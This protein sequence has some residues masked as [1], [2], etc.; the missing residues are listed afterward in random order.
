MNLLSRSVPASHRLISLVEWCLV[1]LSTCRDRS[2]AVLWAGWVWGRRFSARAAARKKALQR[3]IKLHSR[4]SILRP[5]EQKDR[6]NFF[7]YSH[8]FPALPT[9]PG[10]KNIVFNVLVKGLKLNLVPMRWREWTQKVIYLKLT[11][12]KGFQNSESDRVES[13]DETLGQNESGVKDLSECAWGKGSHWPLGKD[14]SVWTCSVL[15]QRW[16]ASLIVANSSSHLPVCLFLS[17]IWTSKWF[18][19]SFPEA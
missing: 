17:L 11:T 6:V 10:E 14:S 7:F 18:K 19:R 5:P 12:F 3:E 8:H 2:N 4:F 16:I 15:L 9:G 1:L 13:L